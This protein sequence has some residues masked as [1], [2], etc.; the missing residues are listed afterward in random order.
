MR[1]IIIR[2]RRKLA[3]FNEPARELRVLNKPMWLHQR[4]VLA[5]YCKQERE[6][7]SLE[8]VPD[9]RVETIASTSR[10]DQPAMRSTSSMASQGTP[11]P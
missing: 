4:D 10:R 7:D 1:K 3:P 11:L 9:D 2:D 8:E 6:V 5:Q